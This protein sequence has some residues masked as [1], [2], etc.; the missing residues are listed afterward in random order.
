MISLS[1]ADCLQPRI[2]L[3]KDPREEEEEEEEMRA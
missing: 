3:N 2:N 1:D